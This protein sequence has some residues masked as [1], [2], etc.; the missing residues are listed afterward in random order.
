MNFI[1]V[2]QK[3]YQTKFGMSLFVNIFER[4]VFYD[5][6]KLKFQV[7]MLDSLD[8]HHVQI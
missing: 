3:Y 8:V 5:I 1:W 6:F 4:G 2:N 7:L